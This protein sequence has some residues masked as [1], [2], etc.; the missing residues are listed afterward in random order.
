MSSLLEDILA[1]S[2]GLLLSIQATLSE[3][4]DK[5][6]DLIWQINCLQHFS[7]LTSVS[8]ASRRPSGGS[9]GMQLP[10]SSRIMD[11]YVMEEDEGG[12]EYIGDENASSFIFPE[13]IFQHDEED[14]K[15]SKESQLGRSLESR[16]LDTRESDYEGSGSSYLASSEYSQSGDGDYAGSMASDDSEG[17]ESG[18]RVPLSPHRSEANLE[19]K[20]SAVSKPTVRISIRKTRVMGIARKGWVFLQQGIHPESDFKARWDLFISLTY[21][22]AA[23]VLPVVISFE[24]ATVEMPQCTLTWFF[25][26]T[27]SIDTLISLFTLRH[28]ARQKLP[29]SLALS[30]QHR[31]RTLTFYIDLATIPPYEA[32]HTADT[33]MPAPIYSVVRLVRVPFHLFHIVST[34]RIY[35]KFGKRVAKALDVTSSH[36]RML[37]FF[38]WLM[39]YLHANACLTFFIGQLSHYPIVSWRH[40]S[41]VISKPLWTQYTWSLLAAIANSWPFTITLSP[42]EPTETLGHGMFVLIGALMTGTV[43]GFIQAFRVEM[44][45]SGR[46]FKELVDQ[47]NEYMANKVLDEKTRISVRD[48]HR[49]KFRGKCFD[50]DILNELSP[51]LRQQMS[52]ASYFSLLQTVPFLNHPD[53]KIQG[54]LCSHLKER[55]CVP[56]ETIFTEKT[57]GHAMYFIESGTI[58]IKEGETRKVLTYGDHFGENALLVNA[59]HEQSATVLSACHLYMLEK[60]HYL[61]VAEYHPE[62]AALANMPGEV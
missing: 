3:L 52:A 18:M 26:V 57:I 47:T 34:N 43:T 8:K 29:D 33:H 48:Y 14:I 31:L 17:L 50:E 1:E 42:Q 22:Y 39:W 27:W 46:E 41:W 6:N 55:F 23:L 45:P 15:H 4:E 60:H 54:E 53:E 10:A 37:L 13:A 28:P 25:T 58:E 21:W 2:S 20:L 5:S 59:P 32:V 40:E 19:P 7:G 36:S 49:L 12:A 11:S 38:A 62:L 30:M 16:L 44:D 51:S 35:A 61:E 24:S 9:P 56:G